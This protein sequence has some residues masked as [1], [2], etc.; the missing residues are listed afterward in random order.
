MAE[1]LGGD[2]DPGLGREH[3]QQDRE[4]RGPTPV[5]EAVAAPEAV[6]ALGALEQAR[7]VNEEEPWP[8]EGEADDEKG[9][10]RGEQEE[11]ED[12]RAEIGEEAAPVGAKDGAGGERLGE[13]EP[14]YRDRE[15]ALKH[16]TEPQ[17]KK[18]DQDPRVAERVVQG[19][20]EREAGSRTHAAR[21]A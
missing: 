18:P 14:A 20:A 15:D 5:H 13:Q 21:R 16:R 17:G 10:A 12:Q 2:D 7:F 6:E 8:N 3:R 1:Q 4:D 9:C 19:E 11:R